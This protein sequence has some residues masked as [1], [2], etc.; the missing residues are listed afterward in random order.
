MKQPCRRK[1]LSRRASCAR[2]LLSYEDCDWRL[3]SVFVCCAANDVASGCVKLWRVDI[4]SLNVKTC[5]SLVGFR[6]PCAYAY[7][8]QS[9]AEW[10]RQRTG[11][12][13]VWRLKKP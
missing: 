5:V 13:E 3:G 12:L 9:T 11:V 6:V 7:T 2:L 10:Q 1:V 8:I 4:V